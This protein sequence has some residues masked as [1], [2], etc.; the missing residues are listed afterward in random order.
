VLK[1][2]KWLARSKR[3]KKAVKTRK[4]RE[5]KKKRVK[6]ALKASRKNILSEQKF[7]ERLMKKGVFAFNTGKVE[8]VPDIIAYKRKNLVFYEIKPSNPKS[9]KDALF[10]KTQSDWI[11]KFC[12]RSNIEVNIVFYKGERLFKYHIVKITNKNI[13]EYINNK[14]NLDSI[15]D[16]IKKFVFN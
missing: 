9:S 11:Q 7:V 5:T 3:A 4:Q 14:T 13:S 10:K 8:G 12:F 2:K 1:S 15:K 16:R 6:A